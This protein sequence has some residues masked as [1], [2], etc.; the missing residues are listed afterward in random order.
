MLL[1]VGGLLLLCL[2][3]QSQLNPLGRFGKCV[4]VPTVGDCDLEGTWYLQYRP[5]NPDHYVH[6]C[7]A[8]Y[9]QVVKNDLASLL[10]YYNKGKMV[11]NPQNIKYR[12][13]SPGKY[14]RNIGVDGEAVKV[15]LY[16][17]GYD[18]IMKYRVSYMCTDCEKANPNIYNV[19]ISTH[20]QV[21]DN[22][23]Q[24]LEAGKAKIKEVLPECTEKLMKVEQSLD[25]CEP[26][27]VYQSSDN[28]LAA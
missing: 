9:D 22:L 21:P 18:P 26:L 10:Y 24:V 17:I 7:Q 13:V 5:D 2:G 15:Y 12:P 3:V 1:L 6:T 20:D 16:V 4:D 14:Y 25:K 28:P 23:Q 19:G 27:S 11:N 8:T